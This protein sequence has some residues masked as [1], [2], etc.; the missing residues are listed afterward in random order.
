VS[1]AVRRRAGATPDPPGTILTHLYLRERLD[2]AAPGR[3]VDVGVGAGHIS[4][5]LLSLGWSGAGYDLSTGALERA[6]QRNAAAA[7]QGRFSLHQGDWLDAESVETG[8]PVDLVITSMVLEHLDEPAIDR[9]F[10]R[11]EREL[12]D[13]GRVIV[14]VP[15]SPRHWG[16]EDEIAG[17]LRRYTPASL[18]TTVR[19]RGWQVVHL[20]GLAFPLSNLLLGV[21]NALVG[22]NE[23]D[24]ERLSLQERTERSG[25][26]SV[27]WKTSFPA[28][29]GLL[30]ND[31]TMLPFH[32]LQKRFGSARGRALVLYC[33]CLP[34]TRDGPGGRLES[35]PEPQLS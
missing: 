9:F 24:L 5:L 14:M 19:S 16:V 13:G 35:P 26:R 8:E 12:G 30:V 27:P 15:G 18:A 17:H 22:R 23:R 32:W 6:Q 25:D 31:L 10:V 21:S 2:G 28:W 7:A 4:D 1:G 34:P 3:F 29:T 11:A 20:T 33:E